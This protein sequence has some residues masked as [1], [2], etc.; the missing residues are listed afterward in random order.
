MLSDK[1]GQFKI[2]SD[3]ERLIEGWAS[4]EVLDV[5]GDIVPVEEMEKSMYKFMDRGG[6]I[7]YGHSNKPIGKILQWSVEKYPGTDVYGIKFV[8]KIFDD[9]NVDDEVWK[10]IKE[11]KLKGFSIGAQAR[12]EKR[13]VKDGASGMPKEV[14]ILKDLNLLEIS[15]VEQPANPLAVI[16]A[17]NYYAKG[18]VGASVRKDDGKWVE[19]MKDVEV[20]KRLVEECL[21][22][23]VRFYGEEVEKQAN[24]WAVCRAMQKRYGWGEEKYERCVQ[25]VKERNRKMGYPEEGRKKS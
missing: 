12:E 1:P 5:Q 4:V 11:G 14:G 9:Y 15:V 22:D 19:V 17:I 18:K 6:L 21:F 7:M 3:E 8:A 13:I 23:S 25:H 2:I 20:L 16:E 10:M 24:P